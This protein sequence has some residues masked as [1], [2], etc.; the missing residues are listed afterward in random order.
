VRTRTS[1]LIAAGVLGLG[2][3]VLAVAVPVPLVALGPGPTFNTLGTVDD[4]PVIAV[5]G[6]PTY[7]PSG[8]LNLTTVSVTDRLTLVDMLGHWAASDRQ[9]VPRSAVYTPGLTDEQ[10]QEKNAEDFTTS[11]INAESAAVRELGLP[12]VVAVADVVAGS[13]A[14]GKLKAGDRITA[15]NGVAVA[16]PEAVNNLLLATRPGDTV[17]VAF[18]RDGAAKDVAI[19]LGAAADS[20]RGVLGVM[21]GRLPKDGAVTVDL[22]GVGGP[23]AGLMFSLGIVDVLTPGDLTGGRFIAGTGAI[24]ADGVVQNIGGIQFKMAAA[25]TAGA[26]VFVLP[27]GECATA[28]PAVPPGLQLVKAAT[29]HDAVTALNDL[30]AGRTPPS[31]S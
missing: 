9:V 10:V 4:K 14:D 27:V 19:T 15:I 12:A 3:V 31:C 30:N 16:D 22:G 20:P 1:T 8:H 5:Q 7:P 25:R 2:L 26:T 29:L 11:E 18:T 28:L 24:T 13:A 17:T 23:S 6:L 21:L